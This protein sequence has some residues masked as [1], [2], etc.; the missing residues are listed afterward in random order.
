MEVIQVVL[1]ATFRGVSRSALVRQALEEYLSRLRLGA[2]TERQLRSDVKT[3]D[4]SGV[5]AQ[6]PAAIAAAAHT[7]K[8]KLVPLCQP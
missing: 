6:T 2:R 3:E 1:G 4:E 7:N 8:L 5:V